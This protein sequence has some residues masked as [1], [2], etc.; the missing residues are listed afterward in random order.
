VLE[1]ARDLIGKILVVRSHDGET[2]GRIVEVEAYRGP[3][4]Q[5]AH[6]RGGRRTARTE[7]MFGEG[8]RAYVFLV[9]GLHWH[10]NVVTGAQGQ[11][12][13]VLI[14]AVEP[15]DGLET[16]SRRRGVAGDRVEL[17]NGPGKLCAAMGIGREHYGVDLTGR[18]LHLLN[19]PSVPVSRSP[20]IGIDYAGVWAKRPWRFYDRKSRYVSRAPRGI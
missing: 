11:P 12:H 9:Y 7:V 2:R 8:G 18:D 4:D 19:A 3:E 13:A 16:M 20:R 15:L 14:R 10:F 6:S 5:A 17:T 1:V